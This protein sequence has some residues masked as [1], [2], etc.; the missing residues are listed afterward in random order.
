MRDVLQTEELDIPEGIDVSVKSRLI[1]VKGP[2]GTLTKNVR[3]VDMDIRLIKGKTTKVTL[4]VW[5]G[6]RKHVACL[7]TIKSLITNMITGVTKGFQYKMRSVYAHFPINCIIQESGRA[8]EIRNFLGE[9]TVRHVNM[10]D[11]VLVAESKAQKDELILEGNDIDN[12]SQSA[13]SI[14][15][16]CRVRN[17]DIRKFLDGIYVSEKGAIKTDE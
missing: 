10:L 1:T 5:Q 6:G 7:R 14:H 4:A 2:R 8:L 9:K 13:A 15:G 11:G 3:H 12:V 17:K 16:I